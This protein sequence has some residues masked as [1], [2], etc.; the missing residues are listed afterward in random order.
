MVR[1][2]LVCRL[3]ERL[4][5]AG[6]ETAAFEAA[7]LAAHL[8]KIDKSRLLSEGGTI[9]PE[10]VCR[11]AFALAEK[12]AAGVP[13]QYL[14]GEWDFYGRTFAVGE[15]VLIPRADTEVLCEQAIR[16]VGKK[17]AVVL[18]LCSGS[19]CVAVTIA[20]EC[21]N[22]RVYAVEKSEQ[23]FAYLRQNIAQNGAAVE[24]ICR[25]ALAK[26]TLDLIPRCD[27]IVANPPYLTAADMDAL[28]K[29][30]RYE[31]V[32]ALYGETDGLF[33]Y[34][35]LTKL[36]KR[37]LKAGGWLYYEIG[38]GQQKAVARILAENSFHSICETPDLCG[39]IR[40]I[41]GCLKEE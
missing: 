13:L 8:L 18:D 1:R 27:L 16:R 3:K 21:P 2:M 14:L 25:D 15:G 31:P 23:A 41:G 17:E 20:K 11:Q 35:E 32:M 5:E 12:R 36:W 33:F 34:R 9:V 24:A 22:S 40:V 7:E 30:V 6:I 19:G 29:E 39:I 4:A 38:A 10:K 28:Q 37:R 26:S